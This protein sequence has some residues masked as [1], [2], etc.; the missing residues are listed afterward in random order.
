MKRRYFLK[1]LLAVSVAKAIVKSENIMRIASSKD[2]CVVEQKSLTYEQFEREF[3]TGIA[4]G[5]RIPYSELVDDFKAK[6]VV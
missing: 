6:N 2:V 1:G 5:L 3:L 4:N